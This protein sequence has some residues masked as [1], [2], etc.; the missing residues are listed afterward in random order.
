MLLELAYKLRNP[1]QV[2]ELLGVLEDR[3]SHELV[4]HVV[5]SCETRD[6]ERLRTSIEQMATKADFRS[7]L[8]WLCS[9]R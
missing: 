2:K 1:N 4:Q 5:T 3:C 7:F 9:P 6:F 8:H